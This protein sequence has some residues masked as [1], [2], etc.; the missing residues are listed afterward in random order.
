MRPSN[1]LKTIG[2]VV[3]LCVAGCG[4]RQVMQPSSVVPAECEVVV[5]PT[6]VPD[7]IS[8]AVFDAPGPA[9]APL[10]H[11]AGQRLVFH[12]LYETLITVD[13]RGEVRGALAASWQKGDRG[14]RWT[15]E[16]REGAR[17]WDGRPVTAW[18]VEWWW[19]AA[20]RGRSAADA[21][22]D[23]I[24]VSGD[25]VLDVFVEERH[26]GVPLFLASPAFAVAAPS[27]D[28]VWPNGS[29]PFRPLGHPAQDR[30]GV[31]L[32]QPAFGGTSPVIRFVH[33]S[34]RDA[35][36]L[37]DNEV[38]ALITA[39]PDVI[40]YA[41]VRPRLETVALP[42]DKTYVLLS[43]SR[44][45]GHGN[46]GSPPSFS[47]ETLD[48]LATDAV[49]SDARGCETPFW[50]QEVDDCGQ[51]SVPFATLSEAPAASHPLGMGRIVYEANDPVARDL[52]ERIV[53]LASGNTA[54]NS[55]AAEVAAVLSLPRGGMVTIVAEG[56]SSRELA[57][58][59]RMG[60]NIAYV[61]SLPRRAA[62]PCFEARKLVRRAPWLVTAGE[63]IADV[64]IPLVDTR[65]HL[66]ANANRVGAAVD[67]YGDVLFYGWS[68]AGG[69]LP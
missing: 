18:D 63:A 51:L 15:L 69:E 47:A 11:N 9:D 39:D 32:V 24:V 49:R 10:P 44:V 1:L 26:R 46:G 19:K 52:A 36:D 56:L 7:T 64:L 2:P 22:V 37:I 60:N 16:L 41:R 57:S 54:E 23:S 62:D 31:L 58:S 50:W 40:D 43:G 8:V 68:V 20:M 17:F 14:R 29:G 34:V 13:C 65:K 59:L 61:L 5:A 38:D 25:R 45:S 66:I 35:R 6:D 67:W 42:W 27:Y 21:A 12:H 4:K 55:D 30:T 53:A 33:A 3:L 28:S 48:G